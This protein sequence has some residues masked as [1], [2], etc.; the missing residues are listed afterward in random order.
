MFP[1]SSRLH[2]RSMPPGGV[3]S[4]LGQLSVPHLLGKA[5][6]GEAQAGRKNKTKWTLFPPASRF[7]RNTRKD[8]AHSPRVL[9]RSCVESSAI[10]P[11]QEVHFKDVSF[12]DRL[13]SIFSR[14]LWT[15]TVASVQVCYVAC[16]KHLFYHRWW[17][18]LREA[19]GTV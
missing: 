19:A 1:V 2:F 10:A 6:S 11:H 18:M 16:S 13:S 9:D 5:W 7:I 8:F 4:F 15:L 12:L 3:F 17:F 14:L